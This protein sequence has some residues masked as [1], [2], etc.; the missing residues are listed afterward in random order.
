VTKGFCFLL[1]AP[2]PDDAELG[3][4][5][6]ILVLKERGHRVVI[7]DLTSGEPTPYGDDHKRTAESSAS[8]EILG[9]EERENLGLPN[10][11]LSD[12]VE[13]RL[14]LAERIRVIRPDALFCPLPRDA[15][16][17]HLAASALAEGARFYAKYTKLTL[18]GEPWY[19]PQ[20]FFYACSH[21][22]SVPEYSFLVDISHHFERKLEAV[23][24]Y[25]SQFI[26]NPQGKSALETIRARDAYFG[27]LIGRRFAEPFHSR[28]ALG[29]EDPAVFLSAP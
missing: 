11:Y 2:H 1:V 9:I 7:V 25:R 26:D 3:M 21:L 28:E 17:D 16:P 29:V 12:T 10:R 22:R 18:K 27:S 4:G 14:L 23:R 24:C 19:T 6:T 20:L 8:S 15:H 13:A 5:G